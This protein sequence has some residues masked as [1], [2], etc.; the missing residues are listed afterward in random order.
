MFENACSP[1]DAVASMTV[2]ALSPCRLSI[3]GR[4]GRCSWPRRCRRAPGRSCTQIPLNTT[5]LGCYK[6]WACGTV[7]ACVHPVKK[8]RGHKVEDL[9]LYDWTFVHV[10]IQIMRNRSFNGICI[11]PP[12][13]QFSYPFPFLFFLS[14]MGLA[15]LMIFAMHSPKYLHDTWLTLT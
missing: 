1:I 7:N 14:Y 10:L 15:I 2:F 11:F 5:L 8:Y 9:L 13:L 3:W 6:I 4:R 12:Y